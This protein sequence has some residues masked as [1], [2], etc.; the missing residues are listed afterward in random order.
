MKF[1]WWVD[2]DGDNF[3][4]PEGI[5]PVFL[6]CVIAFHDGEDA[7]IFYPTAAS[8]SGTTA[9]NFPPDMTLDEKKA[10]CEVQWILRK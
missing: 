3:A 4:V 5:E 6:N 8:T 1:V 10:W 2:K 9:P 7:P